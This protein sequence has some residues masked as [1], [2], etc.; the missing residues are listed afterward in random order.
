MVEFTSEP[1]W[2]WLFLVLKVGNYLFNFFNRSGCTYLI[3]I[4]T[5]CFFCEVGAGLLR[6]DT[7]VEYALTY[8]KMVT[9]PLLLLEAQRDFSVILT[10]NLLS[11]PGSEAHKCG[12]VP[13][14]LGSPWVHKSQ[15]YPHWAPHDMSI[16]VQVFLLQY[17]AC[18]G[19]VSSTTRLLLTVCTLPSFEFL[20][21]P[22]S[23]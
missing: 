21:L 7:F 22:V 19:T 23:D 4:Q 12:C 1:L 11:V 2:F 6:T 13:F 5:A 18:C 9:F 15:S 14:R 3:D 10:E 16:A 17:H 8:F 20:Y